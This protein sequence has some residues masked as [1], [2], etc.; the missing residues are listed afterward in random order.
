MEWS[1]WIIG[2]VAVGIVLFGILWKALGI[3]WNAEADDT[4][5]T[6]AATPLF[7]PFVLMFIVGVWIFKK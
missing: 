6:I 3:Q 4:K 5:L 2:Y 7:W 1:L